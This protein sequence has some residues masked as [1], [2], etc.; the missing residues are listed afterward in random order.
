MASI[1][2]GFWFKF[3]D[4]EDTIIAGGT[5][6]TGKKYVYVNQKLVSEK[7]TFK[8]IS[9][10]ESGKYKII[11]ETQSILTGTMICSLFVNDQL[12]KS[13]K[14]GFKLN[15][16]KLL[17]SYLMAGLCGF[18]GIYFE[19]PLWLIIPCLVIA[20]FVF[21]LFFMPTDDYRIEEIT[22]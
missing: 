5:S 11:F 16:L 10:H 2:N 12:M 22:A 21:M 4:C 19:L 1:L 20:L 9:E 3:E 18:L 15:M 14:V 17:L 8:K 6:L 7:R 13:Y